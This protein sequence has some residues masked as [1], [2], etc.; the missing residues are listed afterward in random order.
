MVKMKSPALEDIEDMHNFESETRL[1][2][3]LLLYICES[4]NCFEYF[5]RVM[6]IMKYLHKMDP[7]H[8]LQN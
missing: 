8:A 3:I 6:K 4:T 7:Q 1:S 5:T 2:R